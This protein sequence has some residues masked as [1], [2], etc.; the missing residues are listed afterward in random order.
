MNLNDLNKALDELNHERELYTDLSNALPAGIYRL[1]VFKD[2][3]LIDKKWET[4]TD[5]PYKLEFANNRFY[6][7]LHIDKEL[8]IKNPGIISD[9]IL[10]ED[11]ES[12]VRLNVE[13]NLN[14][15]PFA[16]EGRFKINENQIWIHFESVPR[17]LENGDIIWTGTLNDVSKR[18][19]AEL[20]IASKNIELEKLNAEKN[21]FFSIIAHDLRSPFNAIIGLSEL[22]VEEIDEKNYENAQ[23]YSSIILQSAHRAMALLKNLM[24]WAQLKTGKI[25][26]NPEYFNIVALIKEAALLY[27]EIAKKK[28]ITIEENLPYFLSLYADKA[29]I[30]SILRNFISN[31]IKFT[32]P[33][34]KVVVTVEEKPR[35]IIFS[36]KD[37]GVGIPKERVDDIFKIDHM[38]STI[39]TDNEKGTGMG[40]TLCKDFVE[41]HS[42]KIWVESEEGIGSCFCFS[43]NKSI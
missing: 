7:I 21:K 29:M 9:F 27:N 12:F 16:W 33:G 17:C 32:M 41:M 40:L 3:S 26:Y 14:K 24:E 8:F 6:E 5:T 42:G 10:E 2:V 39:G 18:K 34:G 4:S 13:A 11:K 28:T 38:Y 30:S 15:T 19:A 36:V 35:E 23:E 25:E 31:A 22:L 1:R 37:T 43:L 20:E